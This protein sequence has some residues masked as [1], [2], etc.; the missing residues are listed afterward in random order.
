M[1]VG[2]ARLLTLIIECCCPA[3]RFVKPPDNF[4]TDD[5]RYN[6][7]GTMRTA[8]AITTNPVAAVQPSFT[9]AAPDVRDLTPT[10][11]HVPPPVC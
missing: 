2:N 10:L 7:R 1:P 4:F 3:A 11:F 9:L 6:Y 8:S 5:K